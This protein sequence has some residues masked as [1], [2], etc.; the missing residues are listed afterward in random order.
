MKIKN[1]VK[2]P[3]FFLP[4]FYYIAAAVSIRKGIIKRIV[5]YKLWAVLHIYQIIFIYSQVL[6][7]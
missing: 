7:L 4:L 1:E 5:M 6:F 3:Q 2:T